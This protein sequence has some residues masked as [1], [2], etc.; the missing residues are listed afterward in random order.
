MRLDR[1]FVFMEIFPFLRAST[2]LRTFAGRRGLYARVPIRTKIVLVI[3]R[4]HKAR[5]YLR[6][7]HTFL[8]A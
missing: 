3:E 4:G 7:I 6:F 1:L 2:T 5:A 8:G